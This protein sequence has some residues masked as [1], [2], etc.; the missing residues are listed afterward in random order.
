MCWPW[1][2]EKAVRALHW[3]RAA[4]ELRWTR[5]GA[6][7]IPLQ[8]NSSS[9]STSEPAGGKREKSGAPVWSVLRAVE[10]TAAGAV[11]GVVGRSGGGTVAPPLH[12][13]EYRRLGPVFI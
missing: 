7:H 2:T 12:I 10:E 6:V 4:L 13:F 3:W 8:G 11:G 1:Y 5:R 9:A